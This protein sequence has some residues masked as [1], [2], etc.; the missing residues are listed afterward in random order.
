MAVYAIGDIQGCYDELQTLLKTLNF[1]PDCDELWFVGDLVNRGP[2]SLKTLRF[3][4]GL[5][6]GAK[7]VLGNHDLHLLAIA[8]ADENKRH[9]K[10]TL[11]GILGAKDRDLLLDWLRHQPLMYRDD[12]LGYTMVHAGLHPFWPLDQAQRL[13][14]EVESVL[15]G[16]QHTDFYWQM[17]GNRPDN[18]HHDLTGWD[19]LRVIT[20]Y[21]TRLRFCRSDGRY[22]M[23][24]KGAPGS[25][26]SGLL[27][28]FEV[29]GRRSRDEAIVFGH[30][31][32]LAGHPVP[33]NIMPL[34]TGCL[35]GRALTAVQLDGEKRPTT[36]IDCQANCT[37]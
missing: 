6:D 2:K 34:D 31:S 10:D 27:P 24:E 25:Q 36:S 12:A 20:N 7:V 30:W 16:D 35:W 3:I 14:E 1:K 26:P 5:A 33:T 17:Y 23:L 4:K 19:R 37:P 29:P 21:F 11:D 32:L 28:W 8:Y 18:W 15:R 22:D 9:R 13:A